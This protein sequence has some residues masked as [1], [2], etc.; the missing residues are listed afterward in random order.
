M[1]KAEFLKKRKVNVNFDGENFEF[2]SFKEMLGHFDDLKN[3]EEWAIAH[4]GE[5]GSAVFVCH[6]FDVD[7]RMVENNLTED[8]A[9]EYAEQLNE[10]FAICEECIVE[11]L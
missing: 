3:T 6:R 4:H 8:E 2:D 7:G 9:N 11:E 1:K 10:Y 5:N